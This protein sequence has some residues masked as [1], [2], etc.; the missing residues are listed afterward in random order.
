MVGSQK[1][2]ARD[3]IIFAALD[4]ISAHHKNLSISFCACS[5]SFCA[6]KCIFA[7]KCQLFG[8]QLTFLRSTTNIF[9]HNI[10]FCALIYKLWEY[11]PKRTAIDASL[12]DFRR[13]PNFL[14]FSFIVIGQHC[15]Q[16]QCPSDIVWCNK[17]ISSDRSLGVSDTR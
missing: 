8:A 6:T 13:N 7:H 14:Q 12:P 9:A 2:R 11:L 15:L 3:P 1:I 16:N 17:G 5:K 4:N 10:Y